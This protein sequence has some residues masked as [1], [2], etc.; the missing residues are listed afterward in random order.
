MS[1]RPHNKRHALLLIGLAAGMFGFA[2]ALVPL[3][4][5]FCEITG[6]NGKTS[7]EAAPV[8]QQATETEDREVTI[9]LMAKVSRGLP[10]D[11]RPVQEKLTV[12]VGEVNVTH[13]LA[14][15][16]ADASVSGQAVPSVSPGR[17][18]QFLKKVECFCFTQQELAAR[19]ETEMAV[20]FYV[21]DELPPDIDTLSLSYTLFPMES[22]QTVAAN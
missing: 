8:A 20:R 3:Y 14:R 19:E 22:E 18:A 15:N 10:W 7:G 17:A 6:L 21:S 4:N 11:V 9:H 5:I 13:Y 16:R 1:D 12:Q 2:F